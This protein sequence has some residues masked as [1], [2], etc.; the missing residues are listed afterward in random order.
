LCLLQAS[1]LAGLIAKLD[2]IIGSNRLQK[3]D[4]RWVLV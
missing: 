1:D 4:Q 3:S 2:E